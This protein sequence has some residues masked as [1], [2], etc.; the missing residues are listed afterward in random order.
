MEPARREALLR[1]SEHAFY[2][3]LLPKVAAIKIY[4]E[5]GEKDIASSYRVVPQNV[6]TDPYLR[7]AVNGERRVSRTQVL[8]SGSLV[9][10]T[11]CPHAG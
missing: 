5:F 11:R 7:T 10:G 3:S 8:R 2:S 9:S 6:T 4:D 1:P